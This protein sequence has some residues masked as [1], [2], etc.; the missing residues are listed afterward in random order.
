MLSNKQ[1]GEDSLF[2]LDGLIAAL[3]LDLNQIGLN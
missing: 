1:Q 3:V 2:A